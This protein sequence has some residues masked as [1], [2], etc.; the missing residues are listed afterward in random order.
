MLIM[1]ADDESAPFSSG[2]FSKKKRKSCS[3]TLQ[4]FCFTSL[5]LTTFYLTSLYF[6]KFYSNSLTRFEETESL[7]DDSSLKLRKVVHLPFPPSPP[8]S[9]CDLID[10]N[11]KFDCYPKGLA[12]QKSC[13][14][15]GCCWSVPKNITNSSD[16]NSFNDISVP[17]CYYPKDFAIYKF[18][19]LTVA[20]F[21]ATGFMKAEYASPYPD[22]KQIL[23]IDVKYETETRLHVKV[24]V[25]LQNT[26]FK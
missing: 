9:K 14:E 5:I 6:F 21:G 16:E 20:D 18:V 13:E 19:N 26:Y 2:K 3:S 7:L 4:I 12:D 23:K 24:S 17:Y 8:N 11:R 1:V 15:R 22:N 25:V 10:N